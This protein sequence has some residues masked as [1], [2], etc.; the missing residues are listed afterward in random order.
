MKKD[1]I[2]LVIFFMICGYIAYGLLC[3]DGVVEERLLA[4]PY[5]GDSVCMADVDTLGPP[6]QRLDL[7]RQYS[8]TLPIIKVPAGIYV[9]PKD[10]YIHLWSSGDGACDSVG[11][12]P[13]RRFVLSDLEPTPLTANNEYCW[14]KRYKFYYKHMSTP[15][16][17]DIR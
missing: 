4:S 9:L 16:Q 8:D 6:T 15:C 2:A 14:P 10:H 1:I 17:T 11:I 7:T 12:I 13:V 5:L 3:C